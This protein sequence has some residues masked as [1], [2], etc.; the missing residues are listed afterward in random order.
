MKKGMAVAL[1]AAAVTLYFIPNQANAAIVGFTGTGGFVAVGG[2]GNVGLCF[3]IACDSGFV[4]FNTQN[5]LA[6]G[7]NVQGQVRQIVVGDAFGNTVSAQLRVTN[8]IATNTNIGGGLISDDFF[9][10][11]DIF[12]ASLPGN[13]GVGIV[14]S[15]QSVAGV[16]GDVAA[17]TQAQ[18]NYLSTPIG[19]PVAPIVSFSLTTVSPFVNCIV[20]SPIPFFASAFVNNALG[21]IRQLV[22]A[23]NFTAGP[24]SQIVLPGSL[25]LESNDEAAIT[26][27]APEPETMLLMGVVLSGMVAIRKLRRV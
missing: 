19:V 17:S 11:S 21:G 20:C 1:A 16:G 8:I 12:N 9:I 18:M 5:L 23:I 22:G 2:V 10:V 25:I 15:F 26:A 3:P 27:E 13:A 24:G 7:L 14:G 6:D 4:A